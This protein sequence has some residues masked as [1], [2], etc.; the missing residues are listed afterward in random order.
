[1][2]RQAEA[3]PPAKVRVGEDRKGTGPFD[4]VDIDLLAR[5]M[6]CLPAPDR[7]FADIALAADSLFVHSLDVLRLN[8]CG[9]TYGRA[10]EFWPDLDIEDFY[11]RNAEEWGSRSYL[12]RAGALG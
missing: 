11:G 1:M 10:H 4:A 7:Y 12:L 3:P 8:F 5:I 2:Q 9:D 6:L